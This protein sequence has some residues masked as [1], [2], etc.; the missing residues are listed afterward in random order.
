MKEFCQMVEKENS[1]LDSE[2]K[3]MTRLC[4]IRIVDILESHMASKILLTKKL[5]TF[6]FNKRFSEF[7]FNLQISATYPHEKKAE[8][9]SKYGK[10]E[11]RG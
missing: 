1:E 5:G 6:M 7:D 3:M 2:N 8:S 9:N 11:S 10:F 4:P